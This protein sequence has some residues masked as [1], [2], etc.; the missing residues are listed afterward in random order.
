[1][2]WVFICVNIW[3]YIKLPETV[4]IEM[5]TVKLKKFANKLDNVAMFIKK[6]FDSSNVYDTE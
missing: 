3:G 1:M 2:L 5:Y 6:L 4:K